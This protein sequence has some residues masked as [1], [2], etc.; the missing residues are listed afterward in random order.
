MTKMYF[1]HIPKTAGTFIQNN[2]TNGIDIVKHEGEHPSCLSKPFI[3]K[4][5]KYNWDSYLLTDNL[6]LSCDIK[7]TVIR[8]PY[9]MLKSY[10]LS[11]WGDYDLGI[12]DKLPKADFKTLINKYCTDKDW[13]IPLLQK[14]LY[15]QIF[16][17]NGNSCCDYAIIY[18]HLD[19][20]LQ[21]LFKLFGCTSLTYKKEMINRSNTENYKKYYHNEMIELVENKCR[22]ELEMFNFDFNGYKG[23]NS[24]IYIKDFKIN[25]EKILN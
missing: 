6:F 18:D 5:C 3:Q 21:E 23:K 11:R 25:W 7:F 15:H 2:I 8:N 10:F 17:D 9:D 22:L 13:H 20:G 14:F 24:L 12:K 4:N 16:D 1:I 19:E